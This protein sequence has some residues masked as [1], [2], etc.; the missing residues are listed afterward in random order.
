MFRFSVVT[1]SLP[2]LI[3]G[4]KITLF[5]TVASLLFAFIIGVT[6]GMMRISRHRILLIPAAAFVLLVRT[7]P[8]LVQLIWF[9][10][11]FRS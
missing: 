3:G 11:A 4:L 10:T 7:T 9:I 5:V 1:V 2:Y 6:V 8:L